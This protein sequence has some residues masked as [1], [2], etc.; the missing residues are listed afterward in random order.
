VNAMDLRKLAY[1]DR[2]TLKTMGSELKQLNQP[3]ATLDRLVEKHLHA[4]Q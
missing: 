3:Q 1:P 4:R 2:D